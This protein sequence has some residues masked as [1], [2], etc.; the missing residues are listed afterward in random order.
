MIRLNLGCYATKYHF[1]LRFEVKLASQILHFKDV[2]QSWADVAWIF[3]MHFSS[4]LASQTLLLKGFFPSWTAATCLFKSALYAKQASQMLHLKGFNPSW[5][6]A[7]C[8][9]TTD[10]RA[11]L[12]PQILHWKG[13]IN[14]AFHTVFC[15]KTSITYVAFE[16]LFFLHALMS[17]DSSIC[18]LF[19]S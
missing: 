13:W 7:T 10:L 18:F 6:D 5:T 11:K 9:F 1:I 17:H 8:F 12:V 3:N 4:K 19:Q 14:V 15:C 16:E 2:L